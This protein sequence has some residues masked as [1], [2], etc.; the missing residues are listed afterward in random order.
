MF[1]IVIAMFFHP[2][3]SYLLVTKNGLNLGIIGTGIAN[4]TT[5]LIVF[6]L[7]FV[8]SYF[9]PEI[10]KGIFWPDK[11]TF[12]DIKRYMKLGLPAAFVNV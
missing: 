5:N 8:Y 1:S 6:V 4:A 12:K 2:V 3:W 10:S 9:I 11:R 7:N